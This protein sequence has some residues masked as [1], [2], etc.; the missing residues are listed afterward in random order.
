MPANRIVYAS[1]DVLV[2]D[3]PAA[4]AHTGVNDLK[5][6][7]RVQQATISFDY[8]I[9]NRKHIGYDDFLYDTNI[10]PPSV[11]CEISYVNQN[12]SNELILGLNASG[13]PIYTDLDATGK[14]KNIFFIFDTG[15]AL[16]DVSTLT[17]YT[18]MQVVG[19][20]NAY[21][22]RY[23]ASAAV[24]GLPSSTV[25]FVAS[26]VTIQQYDNSQVIPS[27]ESG[28]MTNYNYSFSDA[29]FQKTGYMSNV[30]DDQ[31]FI[32]AGDITLLLEDSTFYEGGVRFVSGGNIQNYQ[33]DIPFDRI[34]LYGFG[35]DYPYERKLTHPNKG[36]VSMSVIFDYF[37]TGNQTGIIFQN[38]E[39]DFTIQ[40][41]DCDTNTNKLVY[42]ISG[43]KMT[44]QTMATQIG[45][46]FVFE[47][48]FE[49]P[50][51]GSNGPYIS[52]N[53]AFL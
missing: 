19:L 7:D 26:N 35:S 23:S 24:G 30:G 41:K 17:N 45:D 10:L 48:S 33:I 20:G 52:G 38:R 28:K 8:N 18:G 15:S 44:S 9:S 11:G 29:N 46:S 36:T 25:S 34:D 53:S 22:T 39:Y 21:L 42:F 3:S 2:S 32:R 49:F 16:R 27:L 51:L 50:I 5:R 4:K 43:A 1:H 40:L 14:D 37:N 31:N 13:S 6:I 47:G 12:N